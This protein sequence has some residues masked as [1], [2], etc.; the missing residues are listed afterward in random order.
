MTDVMLDAAYWEGVEPGTE[1]L[2]DQWLVAEGDR[3]KRGQP[4]AHAVLVKSSLEVT[5][6]MDGRMEKILV[7]VGQTFGR[8]QALARLRIDED[9]DL[10]AALSG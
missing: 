6:D 5:A 9:Q 3:V 8:T 4:L 10:P 2:L 7:P 1:A